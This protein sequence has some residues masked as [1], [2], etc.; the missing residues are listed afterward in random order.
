MARF[1]SL[2]SMPQGS[3]MHTKH[4]QRSIISRESLLVESAADVFIQHTLVS[5]LPC[6]KI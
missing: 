1:V 2:R 3:S 6:G 5:E 4:R